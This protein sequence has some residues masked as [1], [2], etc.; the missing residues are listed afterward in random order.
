MCNPAK[1]VRGHS[2]SAVPMGQGGAQRV[3]QENAFL[4]QG[5]FRPNEAALLQVQP[6]WCQF[7]G[8]LGKEPHSLTVNPKGNQP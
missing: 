8:D 6:C 2:P 1:T 3:C 4:L 5:L 7:P